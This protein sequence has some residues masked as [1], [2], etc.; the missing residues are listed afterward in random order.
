[1]WSEV[2]LPHHGSPARRLA[3]GGPQGAGGRLLGLVQ[4]GAIQISTVCIEK[5]KRPVLH[6]CV[7]DM[8]V[9]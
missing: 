7:C 8:M 6:S 5:P 9:S 4:R 1:M 3:C 2:A